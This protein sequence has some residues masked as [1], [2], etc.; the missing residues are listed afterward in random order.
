MSKKILKSAILFLGF[1]LTGC[2]SLIPKQNKSS[3]FATS[4]DENGKLEKPLDQIVN[5]NDY[6]DIQ[7]E[8]YELLAKINKDVYFNYKE[9]EKD[10][11]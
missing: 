11:Q 2:S 8:K 4:I 5:I 1:I 9:N 10:K 7:Y 3:N 6:K